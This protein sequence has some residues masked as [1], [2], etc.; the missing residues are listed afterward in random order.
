MKDKTISV[1]FPAY[2]DAATIGKLVNNAIAALESLKNDYEI[3]IV[4]DGSSDNTKEV[5]DGLKEKNNRIKAIH[6]LRNRGYGGALKVGFANCTK[7]LIFYTDGDG[8]YDAR[9]LPRLF[10][11]MKDNVDMVNGYKTHRA[12]P[13]YRIV[14]GRLYYWIVRLAFRL[15]LKDI[16]CDFRLMR[17]SIFDKIKLESDS[18]A[19]CIEMMKKIQNSGYRILEVPIQHYPRTHGKSQFF[20]LSNLLK[21]ALEL[22]KFWWKQAIKKG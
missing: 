10:S 9:E 2:N 8:Q 11:L 22:T 4:N 12:D 19:V 21:T 15:K 13:L 20:N 5:L 14:M 6:H 18:G 1:F 7:D 16:T 3:I 17:R